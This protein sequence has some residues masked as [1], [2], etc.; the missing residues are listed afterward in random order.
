MK[1]NLFA[2]IILVV[3]IA[4]LFLGSAQIYQS[5]TNLQVKGWLFGKDNSFSGENTWGTTGT[6]DTLLISGVDTTCVVFIT[7]KTASGTLRY[8]VATAGDTIFVTSSASETGGTDKYSYLIVRNGY[9]AS[10]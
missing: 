4:L 6:A 10:D 3:L 2:A 8:D 7:P 5:T 1:K 9:G